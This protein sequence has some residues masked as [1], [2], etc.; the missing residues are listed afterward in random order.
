HG[1]PFD[2]LDKDRRPAEEIPLEEREPGGYGIFLVKKNYKSV[3]YKHEELFGQM[4]N[5]L[6]M[7]LEKD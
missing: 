5:H 6:T 4:A 1:K 2:P 7:L 3:E